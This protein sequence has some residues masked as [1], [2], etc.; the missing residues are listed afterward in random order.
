MHA[1]NERGT[2]P[3]RAATKAKS[4]RRQRQRARCR[5]V[6]Q[7]A[8]RRAKRKTDKKKQMLRKTTEFENLNRTRNESTRTTRENVRGPGQRGK[9]PKSA[10]DSLAPT[11]D[12]GKG[13]YEGRS[14]QEC[15]RGTSGHKKDSYRNS[16]TAFRR[17]TS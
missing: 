1:H 3:R 6:E 13:K 15:A 10:L 17:T 12:I 11:F 8:K 16:S 4:A 9:G 5:L 2:G 14:A 7:S